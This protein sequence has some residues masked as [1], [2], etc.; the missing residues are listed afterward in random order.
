MSFEAKW[1]KIA[2]D[3]Q[4]GRLLPYMVKLKQHAFLNLT[5]ELI[6]DPP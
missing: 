5:S 4:T 3:I 2:H 6:M 1:K